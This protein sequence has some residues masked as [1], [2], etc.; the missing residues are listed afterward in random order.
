MIKSRAM[1]WEESVACM[2]E[3]RN[4]YKVL[5]GKPEGKIIWKTGVQMKE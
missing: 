1:R 2:G 3:I 4:T 5:V